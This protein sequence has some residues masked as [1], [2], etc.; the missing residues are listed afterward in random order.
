MATYIDEITPVSTSGSGPS[1]S[2]DG[3]YV[4]FRSDASNLVPGDTNG[5][6]DVFVRDLQTGAITRVSTNASGDQGNSA[7]GDPSISADGRYVAFYSSASNLVPGDTNFLADVFVRDLQTGAI[8]RVST[9][10]S[11]VQGN[12]GEHPSV[13]SWSPSISADGRYVAFD[14]YASN[15]VPG[16]TNGYADVFVRDLQTG[17]ITRVSTNASGDQGNSFSS[18]P[19][20]SA[21]G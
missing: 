7:S 19:S 13:S 18:N 2:A 15:L 9:N 5:T 1:I 3:R 16:D 20:I 4:A 8:T 10:A 11:G 14:S 21:D 17:A 6:G 12:G